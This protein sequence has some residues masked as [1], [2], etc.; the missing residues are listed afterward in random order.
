MKKRNFIIILAEDIC[1]N[2]GCYGDKNAKTPNLDAFAKENIR[3]NYCSSVAPVCSPA[4]TSL[5]L[6]MVASTAG[7]GQHRTD[8][9]LPSY[10][11]TFGHYM[12]QAGYFTA[13]GKKDFNFQFN[14]NSEEF[15]YDKHLKAIH[16]DSF[17][18]AEDVADAIKDSIACNKPIYMSPTLYISHQSNYGY[19]NNTEEHR[20][21]IARQQENE[22]QDRNSVTVPD[23][24]YDTEHSREIWA[25]YHE[26]MSAIDRMFAESIEEIKKLGQYDDSIIIFVGDNGHGIPQ[27]KCQ[28]WDEGVHVPCIIHLPK[29][30]QNQIETSE[31]EYGKYSN[32]LT[33]FIDFLP[34]ALSLAGQEIPS[35]LQGN[36]MLGDNRVENPT[37]IFSFSEKQGEMFESS[38]CIRE[39]DKLYIADFAYSNYRHP[40]VYEI[41]RAP[42]FCNSMMRESVKHNAKNDSRL[43]YFKAMHRV[44]EQLY[45]MKSDPCQLE[46]LSALQKEENKRMRN[47]LLNFI[48]KNCDGAFMP[49]VLVFENM[50]KTNLTPREI[51]LD[52]NLYPVKDLAN[53]WSNL[54]DGGD[55]PEESIN[56]C[57]QMM[58][59]QF[60]SKRNDLET[61][62]KLQKSDSETVRAYVS[63]LLED[64]DMLLDI[65]KHTQNYV[66]ILFMCDR[67]LFE[68]AD[69][70]HKFLD[71]VIDRYFT[72]KNFDL[73]PQA[74]NKCVYSMKCGIKTIALKT[75]YPLSEEVTNTI[76]GIQDKENYVSNLDTRLDLGLE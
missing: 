45:D 26:K 50:M 53:V 75:N 2:L 1:A 68:K 71:I 25:Q 57:A 73:M 56:P 31:D 28:L 51:F 69:I 58:I 76:T 6:G 72:L 36:I 62:K 20:E 59:A 48:V 4:R 15:G 64:F 44:K 5:E 35:H 23:Y 12:Q 32:R 52:E 43:A 39:Q 41:I 60:A 49:E 14:P 67:F 37:E 40:S 55:F 13:I 17:E 24:H 30:L 10:I 54:L 11:R 7:V 16:A 34:T 47:K 66:I 21:S 33:S 27:G 18:F 29:D 38:R 74:H 65:V 63:L 8:R 22:K 42:W 61:L 3:F 70:V 9:P 46:N 19:T